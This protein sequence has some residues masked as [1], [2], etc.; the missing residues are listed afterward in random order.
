MSEYIETPKLADKQDELECRFL[1]T[2][3]ARTQT[4]HKWDSGTHALTQYGPLFV[5]IRWPAVTTRTDGAYYS[6]SIAKSES[7]VPYY[8]SGFNEITWEE[9]I[10]VLSGYVKPRRAEQMRLFG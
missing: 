4:Q 1:I 8:S 7:A 3:Y 9:V 10:R 6:L 5:N 2:L